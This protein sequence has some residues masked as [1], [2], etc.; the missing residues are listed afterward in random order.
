MIAF[1]TSFRA[2]ALAQDWDHHV[3]MLERAIRSMLAQ[4]QGECRV[5]V[6][7]HEIPDTPL[8]HEPRVHFLPVD[9]PPPDRNNDDM[10]VDKVLKLS[11]GTR[12]A[13]AKGCEYVV[14]TDAD[15]LV[16][17]RIAAV[18][19]DHRGENGWYC[20]SVMFYTYGG[21]FMRFGSIAEPASG[22]FA[23]VR[24]DLLKFERPPFSGAWTELVIAGGESNYLRLLGQ[25]GEMVN[26]LAAAG[27]AHYRKHMVNEGHPLKPLS[28]PAIVMINHHDSTSFIGGGLGSYKSVGF[29]TTV[30]GFFRWLPSVRLVTQ[31][32]RHEF[33]IPSKN[34]IPRRY[35]TGTSIF[36]R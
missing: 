25:R 28:F 20:P 10:C 32:L 2:R 21:R 29:Q 16:S 3:L 18:V 33:V 7:C 30:R 26:T 11:A 1:V 8:T 22:P 15:D 36:W 4:A 14:F 31:S 35:R 24:A 9:F 34:E 19:A 5:V 13:Q 6:A 23:I 12:W 27:L 17:N